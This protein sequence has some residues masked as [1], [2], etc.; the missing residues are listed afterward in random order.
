MPVVNWKIDAGHVLL[1]V[2]TIVGLAVSWGAMS[3]KMD[4]NGKAI[5]TVSTKV[6]AITDQV[7]KIRDEQVRNS[8]KIEDIERM[9]RLVPDQILVGPSKQ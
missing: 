7:G 6:D 1:V 2:I 3:T 9:G 5:N 4:D 8:T